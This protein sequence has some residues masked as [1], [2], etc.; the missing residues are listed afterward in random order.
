M[1]YQLNIREKWL[2][3]RGDDFRED[4]R[5]KKR[6]KVAKAKL[7]FAVDEDAD[8]VETND[9]DGKPFVMT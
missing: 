4:K 8:E 1:S 9:A 3:I 2:T 5:I 6:K 7:S